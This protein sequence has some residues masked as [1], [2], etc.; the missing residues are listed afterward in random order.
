ML[1]KDVLP[2]STT[3]QKKTFIGKNYFQDERAREISDDTLALI[4]QYNEIV[5]TISKSF[6]E[7]DK[8]ISSEEQK[9][10]PTKS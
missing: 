9:I 10:L 3:K 8:I 5:E 6:L 2:S 1:K 7:Y 4:G